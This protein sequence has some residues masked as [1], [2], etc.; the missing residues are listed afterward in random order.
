MYIVIVSGSILNVSPVHLSGIW[1][2][3]WRYLLK[4]VLGGH[5]VLSGH[6]SIP[7]GCPFNTGFTVVEV[8]PGPQEAR[9][10]LGQTELT[11][12]KVLLSICIQGHSTNGTEQIIRWLKN[13][14]GH[15]IH[16]GPYFHSDHT[17][18]SMA[19]HL[20]GSSL[21]KEHLDTRIFNGSKIHLVLC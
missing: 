9:G 5:P 15:L 18:L 13:L 17:K 7:R 11:V 8:P 3:I 4:P 19:R 6:Y 14:T 1:H 10:E 2:L 20:K 21:W 16:K 12:F